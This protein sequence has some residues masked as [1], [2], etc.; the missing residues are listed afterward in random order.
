MVEG[1]L[2][3]GFSLIPTLRCDYFQINGKQKTSMKVPPVSETPSTFEH[4][5][6]SATHN[7]AFGSANYAATS[8]LP[9]TANNTSQS[10]CLNNLQFPLIFLTTWETGS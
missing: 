6:K 2:R 1:S 7:S 5:E 10:K 3:I 9:R 4:N 8:S